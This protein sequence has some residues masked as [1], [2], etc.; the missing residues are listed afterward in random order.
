M[1]GKHPAT[2]AAVILSVMVLL[3]GAAAESVLGA[4]FI[5]G[6]DGAARALRPFKWGITANIT[7]LSKDGQNVRSATPACVSAFEYTFGTLS[8]AGISALL[9]P[10]FAGLC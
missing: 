1:Q 8:A 5:E 10:S 9:A 3:S 6:V 4:R 2:T 7:A